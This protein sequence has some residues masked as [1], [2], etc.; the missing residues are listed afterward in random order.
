MIR[1]LGD[2]LVAPDGAELYPFPSA[3]SA[4]LNWPSIALG[5]FCVKVVLAE[6]R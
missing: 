1:Y 3:Q 4:S 2:N 5:L 6:L